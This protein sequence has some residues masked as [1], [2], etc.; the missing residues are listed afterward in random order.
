[1]MMTDECPIYLQNI[2]DT[3]LYASTHCG[4]IRLEPGDRKEVTKENAEPDPP[5]L[6]DDDL[7]PAVIMDGGNE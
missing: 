1:M 6:P 4:M 3:V 2:G 5:V 7:Y